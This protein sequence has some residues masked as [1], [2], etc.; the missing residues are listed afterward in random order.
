VVDLDVRGVPLF[1]RLDIIMKGWA[2]LEP[3]QVL[4][5]SNDRK[6]EP[7]RVLFKTRERGKHEWHYRTEGPEQWVVEIRKL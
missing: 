5:V 4:R 3:G 1:Q 7:L 6:P 2:A